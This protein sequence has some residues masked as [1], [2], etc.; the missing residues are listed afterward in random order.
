M[1]GEPDFFEEK[2]VTQQKGSG[3]KA[4]DDEYDVPEEDKHEDYGYA[5][6]EY[7]EGEEEEPKK[8]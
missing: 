3:I 5:G 1:E 7:G 2:E 8:E 4:E 6:M